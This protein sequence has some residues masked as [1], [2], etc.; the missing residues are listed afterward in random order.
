MASRIW[1]TWALTLSLEEEQRQS[2]EALDALKSFGF[3]LVS[4]S[5]NHAFDLKVPGIQNTLREAGRLNL[6]HAGTGNT[7]EEALAPGYLHT[8]KGTVALI[9][10]ASGEV[11]PGGAAT[12]T[13]P[14]VDEIR[15]H[16]GRLI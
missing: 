10:M 11:A 5:N 1:L 12:P 7:L 4:L 16:R 2:R 8:P 6:A 13:R 15:V 3:N 9:G 14:D